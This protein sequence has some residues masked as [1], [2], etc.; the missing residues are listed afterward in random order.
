MGSSGSKSAASAAKV[1]QNTARKAAKSASQAESQPMPAAGQGARNVN[2]RGEPVAASSE[3]KNKAVLQDAS[4]PSAPRPDLL[5]RNL[6]SLGQASAQKHN[7]TRYTPV[8]FLDPDNVA[9]RSS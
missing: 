7:P 1:A 6:A 8:S 2:I 4:D 3:T 9:E 5:A